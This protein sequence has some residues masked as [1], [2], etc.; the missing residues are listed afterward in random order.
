MTHPRQNYFSDRVNVIQDERERIVVLS[1]FNLELPI[2]G[3]F[4]EPL[5]Y[6][7]VNEEWA[8]IITGAVDLLTEV[9]VW[10]DAENE[11]YTGIRSILEFLKGEIIVPFDCDDVEACL[12][13]SV[14]INAL[15]SQVFQNQVDIA[16]HDTLIA[17]NAN[18]IMSLKDR[19][20][21]VE[22][23]VLV[24]ADGITQNQAD[25]A[26]HDILI[27]DNI[28]EIV[29]LKA[30]DDNFQLQISSLSSQITTNDS[31]LADH[32]ARISD[33]EASGGGGG[34]GGGIVTSEHT[35][36]NPILQVTSSVL[37]VDI[38]SSIYSHQFT[39]SNALI[40][41]TT[42]GFNTNGARSIRIAI[43]LD[44]VVGSVIAE[45]ASTLRDRMIVSE[46]FTGLNTSAPTDISLMFATSNADGSARIQ[47]N[48]TLLHTIIEY[49]EVVPT[50]E[51]ILVTFD[52]GGHA[53]TLPDTPSPNVGTIAV[54]G[55]PLNALFSNAINIGDYIA[56]RI[57][58]GANKS[59]TNY[60]IDYFV[61]AHADGIVE[62]WLDGVFFQNT[63]LNVSVMWDTLTGN[64]GTS[65][66]II[67]VR[68]IAVI[69]SLVTA[70]LDNI[71][72]EI[73]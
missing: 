50:Q 2:V 40:I 72:F 1:E 13:S 71:S 27:D 23:V 59:I 41:A 20:A 32:E 68:L 54:N 37:F 49:G 26:L 62:I 33:I 58:L 47:Q 28:N 30:V 14:I 73:P 67:E 25:I 39:H 57:D 18:E 5:R 56:L 69:N 15:S 10:K 53:Y 34:G 64:L 44:G 9:A 61:N 66:Q 31:E 51:N 43:G 65:A 52:P 21:V 45:R 35:S 22:Q 29:A 46:T 12:A 4:D 42:N 70:R 7:K 55:N 17:D 8:K 63:S 19:V 36:S 38:P 24:N 16:L 6:Y 48:D 60:S 11:G 3:V